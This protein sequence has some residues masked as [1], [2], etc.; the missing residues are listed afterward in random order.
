MAKFIDP[1]IFQQ[2]A[3]ERSLKNKVFTWREL[4]VDNKI[5]K[6]TNIEIVESSFP[7]K[8]NGILSCI[9][10]DQQELKVWSPAS[11]LTEIREQP[12]KTAFFRSHGV[13][14]HEKNGKERF[15]YDLAFK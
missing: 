10:T 1:D 8:A 15:E 4:P 12:L 5:Y 3:D 7:G 2:L 13:S 6:V 14:T 9:T 11:M